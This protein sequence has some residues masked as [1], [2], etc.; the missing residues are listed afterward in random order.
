MRQ[1]RRKRSCTNQTNPRARIALAHKALAISPLCAD[2]YVL[3]AEEEAKL[4]RRWNTIARAS[5]R[6]SRRLEPKGSS[7]MPDISGV[8]SKPGPTCA[9]ER[10]WPLSS[11]CSARLM[12]RSAAKPQRQPG[13]PLS[14]GDVGVSLKK[15]DED[16][17]ALW[18]YTQALIAFREND[19]NDKRAEQLAKK[20]GRRIV[21]FPP[22]LRGQRRRS[23][24]QMGTSPW[25][26]RTRRL[27]TSTNG[28]STG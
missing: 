21:T 27:N 1:P 28:A 18:L 17:S 4:R 12:P 20:L 8:S 16:S 10:V 14:P 13:D 5:R 24:R 9:H 19:A 2:A 25:A 6:V 23:H 3:L 26:A 11:T 22:V 7:S 15:Y